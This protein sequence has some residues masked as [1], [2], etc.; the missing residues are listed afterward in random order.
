MAEKD[1]NTSEEKIFYKIINSAINKYIEKGSTLPQAISI[2][3]KEKGLNPYKII[4]MFYPDVKNADKNTYI[5]DDVKE[6][7]YVAIKGDTTQTGYEV[8]NINN[9]DAIVLRN[10]DNN[11]E[12]TASEDELTPVITENKMYKLN[13]A[14]YNISIDGLET[15]DAATLS[16]MLSLAD[17]AESDSGTITTSTNIQDAEDQMPMD[18]DSGLPMNMDVEPQ[19]DIV[20]DI[21]F[22]EELPTDMDSDE[23]IAPLGDFNDL[24]EEDEIIPSDDFISDDGQLNSEQDQFA[25][26]LTESMFD[27]NI[28]NHDAE[29]RYRM[30]SRLQS[31]CEYFLGAGNGFEKHL[32][33]GNVDDQIELMKKLYNSFPESEKPEWI[34]MNQIDNYENKM[35][36]YK[37]LDEAVEVQPDMFDDNDTVY[38][39]G[40]QE[41]DF[42]D[43]IEYMRKYFPRLDFIDDVEQDGR[44]NLAFEDRL[45]YVSRD[46]FELV[47][48]MIAKRFGDNVEVHFARSQYHP[49]HTRIYISYIEK[50]NDGASEEL[51]EDFKDKFSKAK[52]YAKGAVAGAAMAG[53]LA[54][55]VHAQVDPYYDGAT[56]PSTE[57]N[58]PYDY[59]ETDVYSDEDPYYDG[60]TNPNTEDNHYDFE[61]KKRFSDGSVLDAYGNHFS[62][63]EYEKLRR[64]IDPYY[65]SANSGCSNKKL[66]KDLEEEIAEALR[67]AGVELDEDVSEKAN[68]GPEIIDQDTLYI[69]KNEDEE[70]K[71]EPEYREIDT[72]TFGKEASEGMKKTMTL[73]AAVNV[74]K[75][76]NICETA[77]V[78]YAKKDVSDWMSLDRRYIEKLIREGVGYEKASRLIMLAKQGK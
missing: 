66:S 19:N 1:F 61:I 53:S 51:D 18:I 70:N 22:D 9:K 75:I 34:T 17:Q 42:N 47:K 28:L 55:N 37:W 46:T 15:Q 3:C 43:I 40:I 54:G 33:A 14:Q 4:N 30:L 72:S 23:D 71:N 78:M 8:I 5:D 62:K 12:I 20:D 44:V 67:I 59:E 58:E 16:Q 39:D 32:W 27:D 45:V 2:V 49:A 7:S 36:A 74:K 68:N 76:K 50:G 31:D 38:K 11:E 29:F 26:E 64:G 35:K 63:E 48:K 41:Y 52:R 6:G 69:N 10:T 56:N 13:E 24:T 77:K 60:A 73:E 65:E 25:Q 57:Y 21:E